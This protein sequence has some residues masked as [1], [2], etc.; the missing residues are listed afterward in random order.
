MRS[1]LGVAICCADSRNIRW[2]RAMENKTADMDRGSAG[3]FDVETAHSRGSHTAAA[4]LKLLRALKSDLFALAASLWH[5]VAIPRKRPLGLLPP[6]AVGFRHRQQIAA[7]SLVTSSL[8]DRAERRTRSWVLLAYKL[9]PEAAAGRLALWRRVKDMGGIYL[10][11]GVCLL[12]N[13]DDH[14]RRLKLLENQIAAMDGDA[15]ILETAALDRAQERKVLGR[16][17]ADRDEVYRAFIDKCDVFAARIATDTA[18]ARFSYA[19]LEDYDVELSK[20]GGWLGKIHQLDFYGG[21]AGTE[22]WERLRHCHELV[23]AFARSVFEAA[24][25]RETAYESLVS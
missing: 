20:L 15:V 10:H 13:T 7:A 1:I 18:A 3:M 16:F 17:Q 8:L 9:P 11:T 12:P 22:A 14:V 6:L 23:D 19:V 24:D 5:S 21:G 25:Q 4:G 2:F